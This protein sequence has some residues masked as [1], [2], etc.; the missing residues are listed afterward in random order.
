MQLR[1][2]KIEE[3]WQSNGRSTNLL[4]LM[5]TKQTPPKNSR[6]ASRSSKKRTSIIQNPPAHDKHPDAQNQNPP[7]Q[8]KE[9]QQS[10]T[11]SPQPSNN[12][13]TDKRRQHFNLRPT[14]SSN[15]KIEHK[16]NTSINP[17]ILTLHSKQ[18]KRKYNP[19]INHPHCLSKPTSH[20]P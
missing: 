12:E 2:V 13:K 19:S 9:T 10:P 1:P 3:R 15:D 16:P 7:L 18:S 20:P 6:L 11:R 8:R 17:F 4:P 14:S 5:I